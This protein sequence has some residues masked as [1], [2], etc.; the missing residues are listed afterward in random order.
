MWITAESELALHRFW[1]SEF[2][3]TDIPGP[4]PLKR[5]LFLT[6]AMATI[7][8]MMTSATIAADPAAKSP[9][10]PRVILPA[11]EEVPLAFPKKR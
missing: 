11:A 8:K 2:V 10:P 1:S 4:F 7:P 5:N 3:S 6:Q 9:G